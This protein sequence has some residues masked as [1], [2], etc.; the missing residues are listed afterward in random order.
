[1]TIAGA[2][3]AR[4]VLPYGLR[5]EPHRSDDDTAAGVPVARTAAIAVPA[6]RSRAVAFSG[7]V[8]RMMPLVPIPM[9]TGVTTIFV[10]P[11]LGPVNLGL[12]VVAAVMP[13]RIV[14]RR[15]KS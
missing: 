11:V 15:G 2:D 9:R 1:M 10:I 12:L 14:V 7:P 8:A 6:M 13:S 3:I 5:A 4:A